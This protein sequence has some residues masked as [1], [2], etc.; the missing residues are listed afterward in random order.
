MNI[1][2]TRDES[3]GRR[4]LSAYQRDLWMITELFP[5]VACYVSGLQT[6]IVG[7]IDIEAL[8]GCYERAW[9][10]H[11]AM[12]VRFGVEDGVPYQ[13][14]ARQMPP[15]DQ[16][17]LSMHAD[18]AA[19]AQA[20]IQA[21]MNT[22]IDLRDGQVPL[23]LIVLRES[24]SAYSVLLRSHHV[25][26]DATGMYTLAAFILADYASIKA[27]GQPAP[28]P[29][30][31]FRDAVDG[32]H[33]YRESQQW[34]DDRDFLV[35]QARDAAAAVFERP[36]VEL[37]PVN[38]YVCQLP[39][40]FA[41]R[42]R[43][44]GLPFFPY[45]CTMVGT[46]LSHVLRSDDI[47]VGIPLNNRNT[48]AEMGTV[49]G[50]FANTLPLRI[51]LRSQ[52]GLADVVADV[53]RR[54]K[55][56]KARQRFALGDLM[57]EL[58]RDGHTSGPLFDV[59][60][61]YLR[62]PETRGLSD[63]VESV[64]GLPQGSDVL[65][66]AVHIHELDT[67]G[68]MELIFDYATD[69]FDEGYPIE[70]VERQ[71]KAL[72]YAGLDALDTD[73]RTLSMLSA[74][75]HDLLI[76]RDR[77]TE[78]AYDD[79][80]SVIGRIMARAAATPDAV[81]VLGA[82][83]APT[84]TYAELATRT[85]ELASTLLQ[86]GIT[87]GDRVG[88]IADRGPELLVSVLG[89]LHAGAAYVPIDPRHPAERIGF[90]LSDSGAAAVL[91]DRGDA[92]EFAGVPVITPGSTPTQS[93]SGAPAPSGHD[94]AYVIYTS[95]ST[96]QPKG[97]AVEHHSVINRLD[98]MQRR[99]P[100]GPGDVIL[101][102]TSISFDV[103]VWELLWWAMQ[104]AAVALLEPG[105]EKDPREILRAIDTA[106]VT[107]LHFVPSMLTPFLEILE[108]SPDVVHQ[109]AS[110]RLAFC[111]GEAL[112]PQQVLRWN[113]AFAQY[114]EAA[115]RLVNLYGPTEA[116]VDVS[117]FDCPREQD[118]PL[119]RVPIG[120]P[121]DNT[122]LYVLGGSD[123][124]QPVGI[125]G[126]LC[127]AGAG[128]ARG[129]LNR[130]DLDAQ[131]FVA[132]PFHAGERMYRT[133]DLARRLA[134]GQLEY[135]GRIDRQVKI[136]GN[137]VEPGEIE[138]VL[139]DLPGVLDAV[140]IA[141][142]TPSRGTHLVAFYVGSPDLDAT[143]LRTQLAA[144]IP[145]FMLPA[146]L[147]A[148]EHIP[149]TSSG[150]VDRL[151]LLATRRT[152]A[153]PRHAGARTDV[154]ATL[155]AVWQE[156]LDVASVS[157]HD[158]FY[159]LG[160]DSILTLRVR[161][162]AEARGLA[163]DTRDISN[164]PTIAELSDYVGVLG[165][166]GTEATPP[167]RPFKLVSS[168]DRPR[169]G[170]VTDAYPLTRLQL[171][172]LFHSHET[173]HSPLYHDVF[174]YSLRM[175]WDERAWRMAL[176]RLVVR[177]PALRTSFELAGF[178]EPLQLV[179][180][181]VTPDVDIVDLRNNSQI[182][183]E[184]IVNAH[185]N[186]RRHLGYRLD[187]PGLHHFG[188]FLLP[189][190]IDVVF[191]F[192]HAILDGW[193]VST[194]LAELLHEYHSPGD[195]GVAAAIGTELPPFSE[196][197]RAE[198][199]SLEDKHDRTY[200]SDLLADAMPTRIPGMV[201]HIPR[202][203]GE[204]DSRMRRAMVI[205]APLAA[206]AV[207]YSGAEHVPVKAVYLA[208]N[209]LVVGLFAGQSDVTCGV[210]THARPQLTNAEL[211]AGLF[212]NAVPVRVDTAAATSRAVV[213]AVFEQERESAAHT[214]YPLADI[215]RDADLAIDVA[216]NY[217]NYHQAGA[218]VQSLDIEL[219]NVEA[220]ED[221]NFALLVTVFRDP[222]DGTMT[223]QLDGDPA[224]YT[225][226]QL[227]LIGATY[228]ATLA[229]I[230]A[231]DPAAPIDFTRLAPA[232]GDA[233][234]GTVAR[235]A[236]GTVVDLFL[237]RVNRHPQTIALEFGTR[238]VTYAELAEMSA[239]VAA[240]LVGHGTRPGDLVALTA[241]R[242][243]EQI[244]AVLGIARAGAACV[245]VD[246]AYPAARRAAMLAQAG[247]V[248]VIADDDIKA[249][250]A[251]GRAHPATLP[252]VAP[253]RPAYVLFTSGSTGVPKGVVMPHR[254][255][256]NLITWQLS[257]SSGRSRDSERA[258]S[259]LQFAPLSF[260]VSFQEIYSTLC[261]GGR[262]IL[263]SE[264][265]RLDLPTLLCTLDG[266]RTERVFLPYVAL[267]SLAE[268]AA[269]RAVVPAGLRI[270]V[271]SGEQLRITDEI[272]ALCAGIG[273]SDRD[274][275]IVENQ[276]GPTET[277]VVTRHTM[278]G[279]AALFPAL[280]P[281][282]VPIDN[283]AVVVLDPEGRPV[284]D[285][286]P[287]EIWVAGAALADGYL[288]SPE[289]AAEVF[290]TVPAL[291]GARMYRTGDIGR[292][293]PDGALVI[294]G[295]LGS[296]IKV[297][298]H[299]VEPMEVELA[300]GH[301][302]APHSGVTEVAVVARSG[303]DGSSAGTQLIAYLVGRPDDGVVTAISTAICDVLPGYLIPA[304][305]EWLDAMPHTPSGK[306]DDHALSAMAMAMRQVDHVA[307]RDEHETVIAALMA[308]ALGVGDVG[309][310]DD[311]FA[312]GG[313]SLSAIRLVV[314]IE[315]R[316]GISIPMSTFGAGST[317]ADLAQRVAHRRV[318]TF[319]PVVPVKST[320]DR[321]PLFLVHPIGG[322]VLCYNELGRALP[323]NQPLYALQASGIEVGTTASESISQMAHDYLE[324]IRRIQPEGPYHLAG[325]SLGGLIAFEMAR[326][327]E[328]IGTEKGSL[329][330]LDTITMRQEASAELPAS[331]LYSYFLW[332]LLWGTLGADTP[333]DPLPDDLE[334][335][336]DALD[337]IISR[338][339]DHGVLPRTGSRELVRRLLDVF[340]AA[341][342]AGATYRPTPI[343]LDVTLL[344]ACEPLPE[345]LRSAHDVGGSRYAEPTYGWDTLVG[346]HLDVI[347]VPGDHLTMVT[348]PHAAVLAAHL[349]DHV[350]RQ[351]NYLGVT[352]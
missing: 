32:A 130:P 161:A 336:D 145:D 156:A 339:A 288:G 59:T 195:E 72:L 53:Q 41:N 212:L 264:D 42:V 111:S 255:L 13:E 187:R 304:R 83:S 260:D 299:R 16:R 230:C 33:A 314:G 24:A 75:E 21:E 279:D 352:N 241:A 188:V 285:G 317:V 293:L 249:F 273:G 232:V 124:P 26:S 102:K 120:Q 186:Q 224:M 302:A 129:Y 225:G 61:N 167:V 343:A 277:H 22:P 205:P 122:R 178:T 262:L 235:S 337:V 214:A 139:I 177:H 87:T 346:G 73:P 3:L 71:L 44:L 194:L 240:G 36:G 252:A 97:V 242:G 166:D 196:Y 108:T 233:V 347:D 142:E 101:Q 287:G 152:A 292:R 200:W 14:W 181:L 348:E 294:D 98:W 88:V 315:Q 94:L 134:D 31:S 229:S 272:R 256:A 268:I 125:A 182:D 74:Q 280:P 290:Q 284:P 103:S 282:G 136:R 207:R 51:D 78:V 267:Q 77:S 291:H 283:V 274:G 179:H 121:I 128:V 218:L 37:A 30:T 172:M 63:I 251:T 164:H 67:D 126:E 254:A 246:P 211:T 231:A 312:L 183:S 96:G 309:V 146:Q 92:Q 133:G 157:I 269:A 49:G 199:L 137:R 189:D 11:D 197:V 113:R 247:R 217:V 248:T 276:Y 117:S 141:D 9:E 127:I 131:R 119:R 226:E 176:E 193:S 104:G 15:I 210:V 23:Q 204:S 116:T 168:I 34:I 158:N 328:E 54:V 351:S 27:T 220:H 10:R 180:P 245:P 310:L 165:D 20:V 266:T 140:V 106:K 1:D 25:A 250:L 216:F 350:E 296:Q 80:S 39:R 147:L 340:R 47:T 153:G 334:S 257:A 143:A 151:A 223:L 91:T 198:R 79:T 135:L 192:H 215:Q 297:R 18:P 162:L 319:D 95:G 323:D 185:I 258:P 138:N 4:A 65:T 60:V 298:G 68:P 76:D 55:N 325:W 286:V 208:A 227:D 313:D 261:G 19:A 300:V 305:F 5:G 295:R 289:L 202:G 243:P 99:Y 331:K 70:S 123:Q 62:L 7:D 52:S 150:K 342:R 114:G 228:L 203:V 281:I 50:H 66:L 221:T 326:Q 270:I 330:L 160:G 173:E 155:V 191:S 81:A 320:G 132:D 89:A 306:R 69:V 338:A 239:A 112:R 57:S 86:R 275:L 144:R 335:D 100:I 110:L 349:A 209:L 345:V 175:T 56:T 271:S 316:Y 344:R 159:D 107:V 28:L 115:P 278:T 222:R 265:D 46:Y 244:A 253:E 148:V 85:T 259:T 109:A 301:A 333:V 324:A 64:E 45:L 322:N 171:G 234:A 149:V 8:I 263:L 154:Q 190:H 12:R 238:T 170:H 17:D 201:H 174:R 48:P 84:L 163:L 90:V 6:R 237:D 169:L 58:R 206:D 311:F 35:D 327:L 236:T 105:G 184:S 308:D 118:V 93:P 2:P 329:V 332:E 43:A 307:P 341:W 82:D 29:K 40:E 213:Q 303:S 219:V 38:R 321:P 318:S